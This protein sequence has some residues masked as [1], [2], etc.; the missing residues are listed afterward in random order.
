MSLEKAIEE[1]LSRERVLIGL[2]FDGTLAPIVEHP[3]LASPA[4]GLVGLLAS[5]AARNE[6]DVVVI[7]GRSLTDLR[8][9]LGEAAGVVMVG[10]HGND[11]GGKA[12]GSPALDEAVRLI[13]ALATDL[14]GAVVEIKPNSIAFHYRRVATLAAEGARARIKAWAAERDDIR[15]LEGKK[16]IEVTTATRTKGD[17]IR[18]HADGAGIIYIGD[19]VTDETVFGVL[20]PAD[21]GVKVGGGSTA[22]RFRVEDT[23]AVLSIL[24]QVDLA[25]G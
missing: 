9:R 21:V 18:D 3:D 6:V 16:V 25:L 12:T 23:A 13:N 19:D 5:I 20:G 14:D 2:D 24:E 11:L 15:V 1:I 17:F 10:E 8:N 4:P 22:A 7:S